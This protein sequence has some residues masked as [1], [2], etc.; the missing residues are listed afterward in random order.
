VPKIKHIITIAI[1]MLTMLSNAAPTMLSFNTG[2][3]P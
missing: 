3:W 1:L 2:G